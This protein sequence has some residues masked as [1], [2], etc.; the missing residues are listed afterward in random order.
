MYNKELEKE[1]YIK[2]LENQN[3]YLLYKNKELKVKYDE[4]SNSKSWKL[5]YPMRLL[6]YNYKKLKKLK[7]QKYYNYKVSNI[8]LERQRNQTLF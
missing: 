6:L 5:T 4:L 1:Q 2:E 8:E 7:Y 3:A